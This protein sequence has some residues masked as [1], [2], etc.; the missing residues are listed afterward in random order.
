MRV[1]KEEAALIGEFDAEGLCL[2]LFCPGL[3]VSPC[4]IGRICG[5]SVA[6]AG[7][8]HVTERLTRDADEP[9]TPCSLRAAS[10]IEPLS[11]G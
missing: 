5:W 1:G 9:Q 4:A 6:V 10:A 2:R 8:D 3:H 11:D 7:F